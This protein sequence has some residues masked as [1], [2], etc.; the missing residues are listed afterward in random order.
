MLSGALR[1]SLPR[2][3]GALYL[4]TF[5]LAAAA[6]PHRHRNDLDDLLSEGPSNSGILVE[7]RPGGHEGRTLEGFRLVPDESCL[8]CFQ[9]DFP[10][11]GTAAG[12][13]LPEPSPLIKFESI[14][15]SPYPALRARPGVSRAPP[16]LV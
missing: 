16:S 14:L 3:V 5:F 8:A 7:A 2:R 12:P 9:H 13:A 10:I 15:P 6:A 1:G 4:L 11:G